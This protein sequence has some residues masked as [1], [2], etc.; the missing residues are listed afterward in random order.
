MPD[1]KYLSRV[2][3]SVEA[4]SSH[5]IE[6]IKNFYNK[7][8]NQEMSSL[9]HYFDLLIQHAALLIINDLPKLTE[10]FKIE[11]P[12]S[13]SLTSMMISNT[14][15]VSCYLRNIILSR[16]DFPLNYGDIFPHSWCL[17]KSVEEK[18]QN[19]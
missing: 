14:S 5:H 18:H 15:L 2:F 9:I 11:S 1:L 7:K 13:M 3:S 6:E 12:T 16:S 8:P 19:V 10:V 4:I 17:E